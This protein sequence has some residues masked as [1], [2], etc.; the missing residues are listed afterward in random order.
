MDLWFF[1]EHRA[2]RSGGRH[3][4]GVDEG[5]P[6]PLAAGR[7]WRRPVHPAAGLSRARE[8]TDSKK[9]T[10]ARRVRGALYDV[11]YRTP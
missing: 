9:L 1:Y 7:W 5:R 2:A 10:P 11:I 6:R 3:I 4:A 8:S